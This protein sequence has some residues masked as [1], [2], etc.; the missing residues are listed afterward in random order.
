[1]GYKVDKSAGFRV[2]GKV[3][4]FFA[5]L[6]P[7]VN[8]GA[9]GSTGCHEQRL[10]QAQELLRQQDSVAAV[11]AF[12]SLAE[13]AP[14]FPAFHGAALASAMNDKPREALHYFQQALRFA[15]DDG[16]RRR[17]SLFGIARMFMWI[18]QYRDAEMIYRDLLSGPLSEEDRAI[19]SSGLI[20]SLSFQNKP[21][22]AWRN[23]PRDVVLSASEKLEAARAALWAG[24]P[25]KADIL[26]D[27][28]IPVEPG[29]RMEKEL[30][31]L[32]NEVYAE[33]A[34]PV[35]LYGAYIRDNDDLRIRKSEAA[36]GTRF[37][38]GSFNLLFKHQG[39][40]QHERRRSMN[41]PQAGF[42]TRLDDVLWFS[43]QAGPAYYGD[44][45]TALWAG[46]AL[47]Q[48]D[49]ELLIEGIVS[50][51]AVETL[52]ALERRIT[53]DSAS[54][55]AGYDI[56]R[57]NL[58]ASIL[59]QSFSDDN[60]RVGAVGEITTEISNQIG[61]SGRLKFRYFED[62]KL[63]TVGYFNPKRF[64]EGQL[65]FIL[66]SRPGSDLRVYVQAGPGRQSVSPGDRNTTL[67]GEISLQARISRPLY[68]G[69]DF[70][71]SSSAVASSSGYR[72]QYQGMTISYLW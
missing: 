12:K 21:L 49:D 23:V 2:F 41:S 56:Y 61:L 5:F 50:R 31:S 44:W 3:I 28:D 19:A 68:I 71:Y 10:E 54:L 25:D 72:R 58:S 9:W 47:Y 8:S 35:N 51:E 46:S 67:L 17:I 69:L 57:V 33:T 37:G 48:P 7:A 18:G 40:D 66:N 13:E 38:A 45:D 1:M 63:D 11:A 29:T 64:R 42:S 55:A 53:V 20:R 30:S 4:L 59:R 36:A 27:Q 39:F 65:L 26:L 16:A 24:L 32:R 14:S 6:A 70:G 60:N 15:G 62:S 43:V 34:H 52:D 22:Q